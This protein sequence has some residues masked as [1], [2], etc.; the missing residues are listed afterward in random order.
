MSVGRSVP[1]H[2]NTFPHNIQSAK[3]K[4]FCKAHCNI[5][6]FK[7]MRSKK[8][9]NLSLCIPQSHNWEAEVQL[10][11]QFGL[12]GSKWWGSCPGCFIPVK[13]IPST[14]LT[15]GCMRPTA[16]LDVLHEITISCPCQE[17]NPGL[18]CSQPHYYTGH[19]MLGTLQV[20]QHRYFCLK[21][22]KGHKMS[23]SSKQHSCFISGGL[24]FISWFQD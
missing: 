6:Y 4:P 9:V 2:L 20:I 21:L 11:S 14:H 16:T 8:K 10:C 15:G 5:I 13:R 22:S 18:S 7:F 12:D 23:W 24:T 1:L 17:Q 19:T 3:L